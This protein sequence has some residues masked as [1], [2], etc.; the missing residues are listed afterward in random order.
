MVELRS[1]DLDLEIVSIRVSAEQQEVDLRI[2]S[3]NV[4][5]SDLLSRCVV[6]IVQMHCRSF[7]KDSVEQKLTTDFDS[8]KVKIRFSE[9]NHKLLTSDI[10]DVPAIKRLRETSVVPLGKTTVFDLLN[11]TGCQHSTSGL[12]VE[13][14]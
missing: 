8:D 12:V 10:S 7:L 13:L 2:V 1:I 3:V 5:G 4:Q 9:T 11:V 14:K 6:W